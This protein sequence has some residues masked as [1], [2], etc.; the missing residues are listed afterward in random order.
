[1]FKW[2]LPATSLQPRLQGFLVTTWLFGG[3]FFQGLHRWR[4][5]TKL[6]LG[7]G[8]AD[9]AILEKHGDNQFKEI[10]IEYQKYT[11]MKI[12]KPFFCISTELIYHIEI[13]EI[14]ISIDYMYIRENLRNIRWR[15]LFLGLLGKTRFGSLMASFVSFKGDNSCITLEP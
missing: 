7:P 3:C 6:M 5:Q 15:S 2:L 13:I 12:V 1:M 10:E 11:I 8:L 9:G 14:M 4:W